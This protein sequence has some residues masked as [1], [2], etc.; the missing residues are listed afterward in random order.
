MRFAQS[1]EDRVSDS[2]FLCVTEHIKSERERILTV[3]NYRP[4]EGTAHIT[5]DGYAL[6]EV[7]PIHGGTATPT[8]DGF[9]VTLPGNV[10][11]VV[12]VRA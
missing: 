3:M 11:I 9:D 7:L 4:E 8:A 5:C 12:V 2:P 1:R 10:G 6:A